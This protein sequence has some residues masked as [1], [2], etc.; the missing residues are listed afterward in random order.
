MNI[1]YHS[2]VLVLCIGLNTLLSRFLPFIIFTKTTPS[3]IVFLGKVLPSAIIAMLI[4]YCFR[5]TDFSH[6]PYGLNEF[7]A[8]IVVVSTHIVLK[9][10]VISI[11]SGV[12]TYMFLVQS[13]L[14]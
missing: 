14:L 10:P 12:I 3:Y 4:V 6:S 1:D 11:I 5:D 9:V 2:I 8:F 13:N 7:I